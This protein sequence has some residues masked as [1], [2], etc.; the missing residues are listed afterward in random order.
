MSRKKFTTEGTE[1][2][3][4]TKRIYPQI[5]QITQIQFEKSNSTCDHAILGFNL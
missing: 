2:T 1:D 5:T 3:E 4:K